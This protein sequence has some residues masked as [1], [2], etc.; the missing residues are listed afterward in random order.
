M[1]IFSF[2]RKSPQK[3]MSVYIMWPDILCTS[4]RLFFPKPRGKLEG[5]APSWIVNKSPHGEGWSSRTWRFFALLLYKFTARGIFGIN[6]R[7]YHNNEKNVQI[8]VKNRKNSFL[9]LWGGGDGL[10]NRPNLFI[11][12]RGGG[13][14]F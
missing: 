1:K 2:A 6:N 13:P 7:T 3:V 5:G 8:F 14:G 4:Y 12:W 11:S 10:L 9:I